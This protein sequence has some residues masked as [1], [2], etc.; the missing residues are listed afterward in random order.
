VARRTSFLFPK[1]A[2]AKLAAIRS[3]T[4]M[5][6]DADVIRMALSVYD[7]LLELAELN[8]KIVVRDRCGKD[9]PY[10][11]YTRFSYPGLN[12][13]APDQTDQ[14]EEACEKNF[15]FSGE[16]VEKLDSVRARSEA[17]TNADAI[18]LALTAFNQLLMVD[19]AGDGIVVRDPDGGECFFNLFNPQARQLICNRV[20]TPAPA[21][22]S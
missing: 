18:R 14:A 6:N 7:T 22:C 12:G 9:W 20:R 11:P 3:R 15:F 19:M 16:A 10:S 13:V 8:C 2:A 21:S 1:D 5:E 17:R 4:Y